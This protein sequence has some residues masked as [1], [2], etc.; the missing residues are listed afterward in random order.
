MEAC[1]D[2]ELRQ[3]PHQEQLLLVELVR[4]WHR[5][6]HFGRQVLALCAHTEHEQV[7]LD[8]AAQR[9]EPANGEGI[10]GV[11]SPS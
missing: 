3:V 11:M 4:G 9:Q 10:L 8:G 2:H 6:A 1:G 7:V 5:L